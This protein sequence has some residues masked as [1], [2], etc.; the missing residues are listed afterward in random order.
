MKLAR[1]DIN[2]LKFKMDGIT[3]LYFNQILNKLWNIWDFKFDA[4]S[5]TECR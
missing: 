1:N 5:N 2:E 4:L 3:T